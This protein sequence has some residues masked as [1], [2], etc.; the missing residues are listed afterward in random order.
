MDGGTSTTGATPEWRSAMI[1]VSG[2]S[3]TEL[4]ADADADGDPADQSPLA[5]C[6]RRLAADLAH[7][8]EPIAGFNSAL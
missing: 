1:D 3:L 7:P 5:Y 6:L 4:T 8:G 2:L